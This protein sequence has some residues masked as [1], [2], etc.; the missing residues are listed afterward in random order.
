VSGAE[1]PIGV[2]EVLNGCELRLWLEVVV[3]RQ[4]FDLLNIKNRIAFKETD[5]ALD[6][7]A[8]IVLFVLVDRVSIDDQ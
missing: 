5:L 6:I 8:G 4:T 2:L 3:F 1:E 7:L